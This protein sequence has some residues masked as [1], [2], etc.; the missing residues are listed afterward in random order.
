MDR[1]DIDNRGRWQEWAYKCGYSAN[2]LCK[3]LKVSRRQLERYAHA[4]FGLGPQ[5]WLD[6]RRLIVAGE[7]LTHEC[8]IKSV[9][10]Q[11]GFKWPSHFSR[12]FKLYYGRTPKEYSRKPITPSDQG[13]APARANHARG[14]QLQFAFK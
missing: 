10:F 2:R 5:R 6:Q 12:A 14:G 9:S 3:E 4:A 11:L 8:S 13:P 7:M 1:A